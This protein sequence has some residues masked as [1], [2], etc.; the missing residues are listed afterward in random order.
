MRLTQR[1][2]IVPQ[3][4]TLKL[5]A[6]FDEPGQWLSHCHIF[7]HAEGGMAGELDVQETP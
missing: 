2:G 4:G 3:K 7:E 5:V 6:R 1:H